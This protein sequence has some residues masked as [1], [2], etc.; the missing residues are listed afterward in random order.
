VVGAFVPIT[1]AGKSF[2][3]RELPRRANREWQSLVTAEVRKAMA[4]SN[5]LDTA[6][7]VMDAIVA[8]GELMLDLFIAYDK[9][10]DV[11][12]GHTPVLPDREW[13]NDRATDRE[14]YESMKKVLAVAF[15][16]GADLLR[17]LPELRP[18]LLRAISRGVAAATIAVVA[19]SSRS[20]SSAPPSTA[21]PQ[22]TSKRKS[23]KASSS[24][25][26]TDPSS[27]ATR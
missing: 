14:C 16:P 7:E 9:A 1:L 24:R 4:A 20:T 6:D 11:W 12:P 8:S 18:E 19:T 2:Q 27:A 26:S 5:P 17:L 3:L 23:R 25:T 15:P 22:N 21:G 13:I 10:G